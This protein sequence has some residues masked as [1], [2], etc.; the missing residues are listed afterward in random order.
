MIP[1]GTNFMNPKLT[2]YPCLLAF[3]I[4]LLTCKT[5]SV[6]KAEITLVIC[7]IECVIY[8]QAFTIY[9]FYPDLSDETTVRN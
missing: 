8:T 2:I 1:K 3:L 5:Q 7:T 6:N 4:C 9:T